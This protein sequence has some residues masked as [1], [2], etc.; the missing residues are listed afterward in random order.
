[1]N[2]ITTPCSMI[3]V[4]YFSNNCECSRFLLA[5]MEK[6]KILQFF[7]AI[8]VDDNANIPPQ[9][10][11]TPTLIIR[12]SPTPY[13]GNDTI[14]WISNVKQWR[15]NIRIKQMSM[16]QQQ[17]LQKINNNLVQDDNSLLGFSGAE[18]TTDSD[19]FSFFS[20][21][22]NQECQ[23]SFPQSFVTCE[24]IGKEFIETPPLENGTYRTSKISKNKI[25]KSKQK[26]MIDNIMM[27]RKEQENIFKAN[28]KKF[29]EQKHD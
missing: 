18:M 7:H 5:M 6:E 22:M 1:M 14:K 8:C 11:I 15:Q 20:T 29:N 23:D 2:N 12:G 10:K 27:Q 4:I 25:D 24:N 16:L 26:Q 3:N 19:L 9:I 17:Y 28:I 13:M 21:N